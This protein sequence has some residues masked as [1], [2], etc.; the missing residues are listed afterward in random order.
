M[1]VSQLSA[2]VRYASEAGLNTAS[3]AYLSINYYKLQACY[4]LDVEG[5]AAYLTCQSVTVALRTHSVCILR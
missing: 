3:D 4:S 2:V 1:D 5:T